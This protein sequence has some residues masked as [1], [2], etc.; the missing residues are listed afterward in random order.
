M[1]IVIPCLI[2]IA[3]LAALVLSGAI[4]AADLSHPFWQ[5]RAS[6]TG[7]L[8]GTLFSG[9]LIWITGASGHHARTIAIAL[10]VALLAIL[11]VTWSAARM[12]IDSANYEPAAGQM[13][14]VGYHISS[15]LIVAV[16]AMLVVA[17]TRL[18]QPRA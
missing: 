12:F 4:A 16:V 7:G 10:G 2:G 17:F 9:G 6:L 11:Y 1:R 18:G 5:T 13:W 14:F 3:S 8:I 15:A